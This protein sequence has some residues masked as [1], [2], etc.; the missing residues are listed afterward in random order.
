MQSL[1]KSLQ[2]MSEL[3]LPLKSNKM[4]I[5]LYINNN[6]FFSINLKVGTFRGVSNWC[7]TGLTLT[8]Q[9]TTGGIPFIWPHLMVT[10][11]SWVISLIAII[12]KKWQL[13]SANHGWGHLIA[14]P[15]PLSL[16]SSQMIPNISYLMN[17]TTKLRII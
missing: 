7:W 13:M 2:F 6:C 15:L 10:K 3:P 11:K 5:Y 1:D 14:H 8:S 9:I 4:L 17:K 16:C 12:I